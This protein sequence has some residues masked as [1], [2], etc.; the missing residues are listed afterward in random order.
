MSEL[1]NMS[2]PPRTVLTVTLVLT[3]ARTHEAVTCQTT[4]RIVAL[5]LRE[6]ISRPKISS[7]RPF[8]DV[9]AHSRPA[10]RRGVGGGN[11][12]ADLPNRRLSVLQTDR[13]LQF[14]LTSSAGGTPARD[15]R[16]LGSDMSSDPLFGLE[17]GHVMDAVGVAP[18]RAHSRGLT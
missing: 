11:A 2:V 9:N 15:T 16:Q 1:H 6:D 10:G 7:I 14:P 8:T 18:R 12:W 13:L 17:Q 3:H 5:R 4:S